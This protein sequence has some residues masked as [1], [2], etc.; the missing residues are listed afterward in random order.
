MVDLWYKNLKH[1][2]TVMY[3]D[4]ISTIGSIPF[5]GVTLCPAGRIAVNKLN[6]SRIHEKYSRNWPDSLKNASIDE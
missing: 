5:P 1:P 3:D 4:K 6:L 2:V